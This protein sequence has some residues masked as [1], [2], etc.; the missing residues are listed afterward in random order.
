MSET[1]ADRDQKAT[2]R[3]WQLVL[4]RC[5]SDWLPNMLEAMGYGAEHWTV[6]ER[7]RAGTFEV[8]VDACER[9]ARAGKVDMMWLLC[10]RG[11]EPTDR[12]LDQK[13]ADFA[14]IP[15]LVHEPYERDPGYYLGTMESD[16][17]QLHL[18]YI[19]CYI[20]E[21]EDGTDRYMSGFADPDDRSDATEGDNDKRIE[22]IV[23][24]TGGLPATITIG[25]DLYLVHVFPF[26]E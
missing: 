1:E 19:R 13:T 12:A 17:C 24:A 22:E 14:N 4:Q 18:E 26:S 15:R 2:Q 23:L 16:G 7:I 20:H 6:L 3:R 8:T 9:L 11:H 5:F 10:G 25:D 21:S